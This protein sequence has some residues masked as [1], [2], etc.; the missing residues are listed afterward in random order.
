[1]HCT[2]FLSFFPRLAAISL[3]LLAAT[4]AA[5]ANAQTAPAPRV[6]QRQDVA[7]SLVPGGLAT[8]RVATW[9]CARGP[10][11]AS[12]T[13]QVLLSGNTYGSVYWDFP[14]RPEQYSYVHWMT[15]AGYVTLSVDRI[16]TGQSS[17]PLSTFVNMTSNA[18]VIEQVVAKLA[19]GSLA[20]VPFSKIVLVGHSYGSAVGMLVASHSRAVDGLIVSGML[21]GVGYGLLLNTAVMYPAQLDPRFAGQS[22]PLGYLTSRPG[23]RSVFYWVPGTEPEVIAAD[24]A[25]KATMTLEESLTQVLGV[26]AS[27]SLSVPVLSV[28]GDYDATFCGVPTCSEPGSTAALEPLFYPPAAQLELH[29]VPNTGHDLNLHRSAPIWFAIAQ[30]WMDRRFGP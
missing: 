5:R 28:V 29:V 21:H 19:S 26:A 17:R 15:D 20:G 25:T 9:L 6:C 4:L 13:V 30:E 7:V 23:Q 18:W 22:M 16:G 1:M 2:R 11:S 12:R 27:L 10:L 8:Q 14:Y 24:E 3:V